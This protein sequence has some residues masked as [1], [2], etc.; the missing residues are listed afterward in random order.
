MDRL[1]FGVDET[2]VSGHCR[3]TNPMNT[4]CAPCDVLV[5]REIDPLCIS[6][7]FPHRAIIGHFR[8]KSARA[9]H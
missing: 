3:P 1:F 8:K 5:D 6:A 9:N 4:G 2:P 7:D